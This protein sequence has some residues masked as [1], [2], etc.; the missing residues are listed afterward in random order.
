[1]LIVLAEFLPDQSTTNPQEVNWLGMCN[2]DAHIHP[3]EEVQVE[4]GKLGDGDVSHEYLE[5]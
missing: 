1:M 3:E 2:S 5:R 4:H